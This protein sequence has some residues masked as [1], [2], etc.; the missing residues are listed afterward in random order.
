MQKL[1]FTKLLIVK[2]YEDYQNKTLT[3][4]VFEG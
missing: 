2:I 4:A 1:S 3:L